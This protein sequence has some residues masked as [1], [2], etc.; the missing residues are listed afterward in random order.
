V[1]LPTIRT[2]PARFQRFVRSNLLLPSVFIR[3]PAALKIFRMGYIYQQPK[4][5]AVSEGEHSSITGQVAFRTLRKKYVMTML[6]TV[7]VIKIKNTTPAAS[8]IA[9]NG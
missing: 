6:N 2:T 7:S 9:A 4:R 3:P 1:L 5:N 8:P